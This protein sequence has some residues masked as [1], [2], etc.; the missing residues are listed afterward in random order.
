M[1]CPE[2]GKW[3]EF[4]VR[5]DLPHPEGLRIEECR[6]EYDCEW[7]GS[8]HVK[9]LQNDPSGRPR[10]RPWSPVRSDPSKDIRV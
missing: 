3:M 2:T 1:Q 7:C 5:S 6:I 4:E 8:R 10:D 9:E